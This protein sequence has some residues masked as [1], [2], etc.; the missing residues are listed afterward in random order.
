MSSTATPEAEISYM[1]GLSQMEVG[2]SH[3]VETNEECREKLGGNGRR[4]AGWCKIRCDITS[5]SST[6]VSHIG[7]P[8]GRYRSGVPRGQESSHLGI[9]AR[10]NSNSWRSRIRGCKIIDA[11]KGSRGG[12]PS[13]SRCLEASPF[14][15]L[16]AR[17][18]SQPPPGNGTYTGLS[19]IIRVAKTP[20]SRALQ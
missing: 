7:D 5:L 19:I 13:N 20:I 10:V 1:A 14:R 11:L 18:R 2:F 3:A 6:Q 16:S 12:A 8:R 9:C 17:I 4:V 15:P